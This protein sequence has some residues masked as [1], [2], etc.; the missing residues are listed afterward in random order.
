MK[1]KEQI[2]EEELMRRVVKRP[3][4]TF[5]HVGL[6]LKEAM[7]GTGEDVLRGLAAVG[8][9]LA[10]LAVCAGAMCKHM[11]IIMLYPFVKIYFQAM[12]RRAI[13]KEHPELM[14]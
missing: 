4:W 7:Q 2:N 9:G 12:T 10:L 1:K 14:D 3:L 6:D 13:L 11:V 5:L 8:K